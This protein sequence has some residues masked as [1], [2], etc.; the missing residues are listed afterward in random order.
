[1]TCSDCSG[2]GWVVHDGPAERC[3]RCHEQQRLRQWYESVAPRRF[4][5]AKIGDVTQPAA[6]LDT[7]T[8]WLENLEGFLLLFGP[9]G[10]GKSYLA[11]AVL[12]N[13]HLRDWECR[14]TS[15]P[16]MFKSLQPGGGA[17]FTDYAQ[18]EVLLLDDLGVEKG[19]EATEQELYAIVHERWERCRPTIVTTN[20]TPSQLEQHVGARVYDRLAADA[21]PLNLLRKSQRRRGA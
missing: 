4:W 20:L 12:R 7:V 11:Y 14:A 16:A 10:A 17:T 3:S 9:V 8:T 13:L 1:M 2:T 6:V 21:V 19:S 15:A 5:S 18:P